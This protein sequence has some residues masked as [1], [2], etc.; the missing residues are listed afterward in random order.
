M[1]SIGECAFITIGIPGARQ[2]LVALVPCP[3]A[4]WS[5]MLALKMAWYS[6]VRGASCVVPQHFTGSNEGWPRHEG[7]RSPIHWP[8]RSGYIA[9]SNANAPYGA[10]H[11]IAASAIALIAPRKSI[12]V[13]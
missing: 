7:M 12:A 10:A 4:C 13:L 8:L 11:S 9:S 2:V 6:G 3:P 1:I 5:A